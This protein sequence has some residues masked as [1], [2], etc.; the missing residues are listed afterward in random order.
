MPSVNVI[1]SQVKLIFSVATF[2][3]FVKIYRYWYMSFN[4]IAIEQLESSVRVKREIPAGY[5]VRFYEQLKDGGSGSCVKSTFDIIRN[6]HL[7]LFNEF[8]KHFA[9]LIAKSVAPGKSSSFQLSHKYK[10][11]HV[12]SMGVSA[13]IF[14]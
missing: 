2:D 12:A 7:R 5:T 6:V 13:C 9:T 3:S 4:R 8:L 10:S 11:H 1:D 14:Q